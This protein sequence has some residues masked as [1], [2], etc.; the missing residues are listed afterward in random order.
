MSKK[1][2]RFSSSK[3]KKSS[4]TTNS[5]TNSTFSNSK[6]S[7]LATSK[8]DPFFLETD[9]H[10]IDIELIATLISIASSSYFFKANLL[11]RSIIL[12]QLNNIEVE[13]TPNI[14]DFI[15]IGQNLLILSL[16]LFAKAAFLRYEER[17]LDEKL[18]PDTALNSDLFR[19]IAISYI[20]TILST[21]VRIT[22][23]DDILENAAN[24]DEVIE[25]LLGGGGAEGF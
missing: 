10:L 8:N 7:N 16:L 11:G 4:S 17:K 25:A 18:Y 2:C 5:S 6:A 19:K 23:R 24:I 21:E 1:K 14:D 13:N 9:L 3:K 22:L 15:H 12:N 20:P